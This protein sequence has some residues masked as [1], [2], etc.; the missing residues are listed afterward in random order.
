V[1][2]IEHNV[3]VIASAD[4]VVDLGPEGGAKGGYVLSQGSPEETAAGSSA[5]ALAL[6]PFFASAKREPLVK[7][8]AAA[9]ATKKQK[10]KPL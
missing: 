10:T 4:W 7:G 8:R 3:E 6:A 1:I 2:V 9:A 5:T